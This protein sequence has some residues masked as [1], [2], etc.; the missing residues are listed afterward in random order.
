MNHATTSA[1]PVR[2]PRTSAP[3]GRSA[4]NRTARAAATHRHRADAN[5]QRDDRPDGGQVFQG[6]DVRAMPRPRHASARRAGGVRRSVGHHDP[7]GPAVL[8]IAARHDVVA[9]ALVGAV[10]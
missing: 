10:R 6:A 3:G 8:N 5:V 4:K 2:R 9:A 7:V 1:R